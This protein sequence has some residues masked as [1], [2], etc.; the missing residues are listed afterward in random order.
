MNIRCWFNRGVLAFAALL[1][2]VGVVAGQGTGSITGTVRSDD[3]GVIAGAQVSVVEPGTPTAQASNATITQGAG[4]YL[5]VDVPAGEWLVRVEL[6]GYGTASRA[7]TVEA[8]GTVTVDFT[9]TSDAI[10]LDEIVVTGVSGATVKA[11]VPFD[12]ATLSVDDLPVPALN[13]ASSIQGKV[14]GA[15]V[16]AGSGRPGSAPSILL[17]GGTS[18]SAA[19][20]SQEPLYI[21]D[22]VIL[23]G[24]MVDI[25]GNDIQN[26]EIVK[27]AAAASLYGSRAANG[28]VQ[29][30][31]KRGATVPDDDVRYTVRAQ[32]GVNRLGDA[33]IVPQS[34]YFRMNDSNTAFI[35]AGGGECQF[36]GCSGVLLAGQGAGEGEAATVWNTYIT[37]PWPT[38][39]DQVDRF[40]QGGNHLESY[41]SASGRSGATN[42]HVSFSN[43][44][45]EGVMRGAEGF[46]RN[47]FRVNLDQAVRQDLQISASAFYS[48]SD[49]D[50]FS[51]TNGNVLF[52]LTRMPA[53]VDLLACEDNPETSQ[54]ETQLSCLNDPQNLILIPNP[55]NLESANP[56]YEMLMMDYT[57]SRDRFLGS[58]TARWS[59]IDWLAIDG[60]ASYDRLD[61]QREQLYPSGYRTIG[62]S[63]T[64][65][66]GNLY[67]QNYRSEAF[68]ASATAT[69]S[70]NLADGISNRTQLRYLY[71]QDDNWTSDMQGYNFV[72][73]DL[74]N[75]D[76]VDQ[77]TLSAGSSSQSV[78]SDGY[79][80]ITSFDLFDRYILDGL[81]RNDGSSLFGEDERRA[82]YYR[83]AG[84]WRVGAEPWFGVSAIDELK[85]RAAYGTAGNRPSF[86]AQYET[87]SVSDGVIS[88]VALGNQDLKPEKSA[89]L[90]VGVDASF[91]RGRLG[92]SVTYANTVTTDQI[93]EVPAPAYTGFTRQYQ[94]AGTLESS[95]WEVT[96]DARVFQ[97]DNMSLSTRVLFDRTRSEITELNT[98]PF[99][100]GVSGQ[101]LGNV[102][103]IRE[104]E[105]MG[106]FYGSVIASECGQL[107]EG[108]DCSQFEVND[109]G[110]LVY[111]GGSGFA[112]PQWGTT[113][114][115]N[116]VNYK[117]GTP[118]RGQCLN[119]TTGQRTNYCEVGNSIPDYHVGFSATFTWGGL[120]LY[121]LLDS[122]QG[123]DVYNQ[124][125]QWAVFRRNSATCDQTG[126]P[127]EQAK[128]LGYCEA[129]YFDV[130]GL[131]PSSIF[132]E[133]GSYI[134]LRELSASYTFRDDQL[135]RVPGLSLFNG[136]T[137]SATGRNLFTWSDY[138]GYDPEVG[139]AGGSVGSAAIAR[140]DGYSYPNFRTWM[141]GV[142]LNF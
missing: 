69:M 17:R 7:V 47:N 50:Q 125:A 139:K 1:G 120:Q 45:Q 49:Q 86:I 25:D 115:I 114:L 79:F 23:S 104:G 107:A 129:K 60:N 94:N 26:I 80:L 106:T 130:G 29:I 118:I 15:I 6:I 122:E 56:I 117:W 98:V 9:L 32:I 55:F 100:Q 78:I 142:E 16:H 43:L 101:N 51:E 34:H 123:F 65:N 113:A 44:G 33:Q 27:G 89:E 63:A 96:L 76:N 77:A 138:S 21:V 24:E 37:N 111:T 87:Y 91:A 74:S 99:T 18:I 110:F 68:N 93:L 70:F 121:G 132:V 2:T 124:T 108:V 36:L 126:V 140:V 42:F 131:Q 46:R 28:V 95:T 53:G 8:G 10:S 141:F 90:E 3:G 38:Y 61:R 71:E 128:P 57:E 135:G 13:P 12:I 30:T 41:V 11:K 85:L 52:D 4:R 67:E 59:P 31:T 133:D 105:E 92:A 84:A 102:F 119:T 72:V 39:Y 137:L 73:G 62:N 58:V 109:D 83:L 116:G 54:D 75:F 19:G 136:V 103:Y 64:L 82:W 81:I 20:R 48:Q 5:L 112:D 66:R 22:G 97:T 127:L 35:D 88:P 14:A 134:K 40:F